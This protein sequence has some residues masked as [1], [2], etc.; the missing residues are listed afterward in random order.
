MPRAG[1]RPGGSPSP[2]AHG[3]NQIRSSWNPVRLRRVSPKKFGTA[4]RLDSMQ[5]M[6][7]HGNQDQRLRSL[8]LATIANQR[9]SVPVH[10]W[11]PA[12]L[13][14]DDWRDSYLRVGQY[15]TT[16]LFT[17]HPEDVVDL[18][19]SLMDWRHIRHVPVVDDDGELLW[20]AVALQSTQNSFM[21]QK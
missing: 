7:G 16:D 10:E 12:T 9:R 11:R 6:E 1:A 13:E 15:M 2:D 18:A 3:G 19:A 8:T 14:S 20:V 17:V 21:K 5:A 4:T